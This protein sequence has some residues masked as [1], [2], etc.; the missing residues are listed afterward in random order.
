MANLILHREWKEFLV[1]L[2]DN[3]VEYLV[4]GALAVAHHAWPRLTND[5]DIWVRPDVE[6]AQRVINALR[7]FGFASL[8]FTASDFENP[9]AIIQLGVPPIRID[10]I[11]SISGVATFD[12]A[13]LQRSEGD[14][15]GVPTHYLGRST[16]LQNKKSAGRGR[17]LGDIE[18]LEGQNPSGSV[19]S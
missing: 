9:D 2:N 5:L 8:G 18:A 12:E 14:L 3:Q 10:L 13:W 7:D 6:N 4:V 15:G 16:L 1:C 17:D 19:E 11:T